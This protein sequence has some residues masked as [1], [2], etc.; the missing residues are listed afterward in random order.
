MT[1][2]TGGLVVRAPNHLGELILALPALAHAAAAER[3]AKMAALSARTGLELVQRSMD[4]L[5]G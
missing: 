5:E 3:E 2:E 1:D 4:E